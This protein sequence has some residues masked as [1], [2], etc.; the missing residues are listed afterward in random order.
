MAPDIRIVIADDHP[1][2]R[3]A[4]QRAR[5]TAMDRALGSRALPSGE[6][7]PVIGDRQANL[8]ALLPQRDVQRARMRVLHHVVERFLGDP[9]QVHL[10]VARA[11]RRTDPDR[12]SR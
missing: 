8:R 10:R 3:P 6:T 7:D 4:R 11:R 2:F 1:V 9:V 5:Q 12:S